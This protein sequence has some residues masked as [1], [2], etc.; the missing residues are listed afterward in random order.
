MPE[1]YEDEYENEYEGEYEGDFEAYEAFEGETPA[2]GAAGII[3]L[4]ARTPR[5]KRKGTRAPGTVDAL[6]LHQ[7]ACCYRPRDPLRRFLSI[8]SHFAITHDGRILQL[9]PTAA[10]LWASNGFNRRS[11][12]VEFAGNFPNVR[13]RWWEGDRFGRNQVTQ[14]Q[15]DAGRRLVRHLVSTI[16][17]RFVFAHRQSSAS[18]ENDPGPDLWYNVGQWAVSSAGLSDGGPGFKVG[19]GNPIL[20]AWRTWARPLVP[21]LGEAFEG[22]VYETELVHDLEASGGPPPMSQTTIQPRGRNG[23]SGCGCGGKGG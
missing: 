9:H 11:V 7:M 8:T 1:E 15:I 21:E 12:A 20:P 17:I 13:G 4:T 5:D 19:S 3:D 16:G 2:A 10:L 22:E 23:H 6:V 18:R 14:R